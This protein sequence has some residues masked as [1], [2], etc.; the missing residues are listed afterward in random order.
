MSINMKPLSQNIDRIMGILAWT[1]A[2]AVVLTC[3][4]PVTRKYFFIVAQ[5]VLPGTWFIF[6]LL[7]HIFRKRPRMKLWWVYLSAPLA[8]AYWEWMVFLMI[9]QPSVIGVSE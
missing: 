3:W 1:A 4:L 7:V 6:M 9:F 8:L 2:I 5:L